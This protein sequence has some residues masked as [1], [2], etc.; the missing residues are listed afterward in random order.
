MT[1]SQQRSPRWTED[2]SALLFGIRQAEPA[3][4]ADAEE[5]AEEAAEPGDGDEL[6][7]N[8]PR[9]AVVGPKRTK[10]QPVL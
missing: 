7:S 5:R 8:R 9:P 2:L 1:I 4:P 10:I 6:E 3:E